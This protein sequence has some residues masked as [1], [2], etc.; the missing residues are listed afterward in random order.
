[1]KKRNLVPIVFA[2]A[3]ASNGA[4]AQPTGAMANGTEPQNMQRMQQRFERMNALMGQAET[5]YHAQRTELMRQHMQLMQQQMRAMHAM[6]GSEM[7]NSQADGNM[8]GGDAAG[9]NAAML[10]R[11]QTRMD[12]MQ[13]MMQQMLDQ[14]TLMMQSQGG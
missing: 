9:D 1:M 10:N 13:Q 11:M 7:M 8:M 6:M 12:M 5:A 14:Q 4:L 3:L 2:L